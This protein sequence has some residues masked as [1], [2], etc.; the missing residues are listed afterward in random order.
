MR[1]TVSKNSRLF[2]IFAISL[3]TMFMYVSCGGGSSSSTTPTTSVVQAKT[4]NVFVTDLS[5]SKINNFTI[6]I[7]C[8][9]RPVDRK[10]V[11]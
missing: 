6:G 8:Y 9:L 3:F 2:L 7:S 1:A 4:V 11:N 5:D 10:T